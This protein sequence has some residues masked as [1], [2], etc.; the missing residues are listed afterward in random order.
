MTKN[1]SCVSTLAVKVFILL[2]YLF[3]LNALLWV[4]F[5]IFVSTSEE[6]LYYIK[7]YIHCLAGGVH[8]GLDCG[9]LRRKFEAM[10]YKYFEVANVA[11]Y[12][13]LNLTLQ[14]TK[15]ICNFLE[16]FIRAEWIPSTHSNVWEA[17]KRC[18]R[19]NNRNL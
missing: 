10:N 4:S 6:F 5:T 17:Y 16:K 18:C 2:C 8:N 7:G 13:F 1:M 12:A 15:H 11:M 19:E 9:E 3:V 14:L